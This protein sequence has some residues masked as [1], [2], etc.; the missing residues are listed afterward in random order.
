MTDLAVRILVVAGVV[1]I[2][3]GI[4]FVLR[5]VQP[6][7]HPTI[8]VSGLGLPAGIVLFTSTDCTTCGAARDVLRREGAYFREVTWE[9][10]GRL[11]EKAGVEAVPLL[12][13][14]DDQGQTVAQVAGVPRG[15]SLRRA[16]A[17]APRSEEMLGGDSSPA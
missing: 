4:A 1:L 7:V 17:Q 12:I 8:D 14:L 10:E 15:R 11:L 6:P 2:A 13:V 16:L 9:L 3:L 5:K